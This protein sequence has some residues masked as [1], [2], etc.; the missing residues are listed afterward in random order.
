MLL[1]VHSNGETKSSPPP[2]QPLYQQQTNDSQQLL[3]QQQLCVTDAATA[4]T[5]QEPAWQQPDLSFQLKE[6]DLTPLGALEYFHLQ[7]CGK[8]MK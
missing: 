7:M 8:N 4:E 1:R 6:N 3:Y 2:E 5:Q